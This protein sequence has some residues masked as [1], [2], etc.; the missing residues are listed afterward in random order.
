MG[1][2]CRSKE[3]LKVVAHAL[4]IQ[5]NQRGFAALYHSICPVMLQPYACRGIETLNWSQFCS[6]VQKLLHKAFEAVA[7]DPL[8][9][10]HYHAPFQ[11]MGPVGSHASQLTFQWLM[12][13]FNGVD[14]HLQKGLPTV[15]KYAFI[16]WLP[17]QHILC[18][19]TQ[20]QGWCVQISLL[21]SA[22]CLRDMS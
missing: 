15:L 12:V 1:K 11:G 5:N 13:W 20:L 8:I 17:C 6:S 18:P 4:A 22:H 14:M 19:G 2:P 3:H 9:L 7:C 21:V 10:L 16:V